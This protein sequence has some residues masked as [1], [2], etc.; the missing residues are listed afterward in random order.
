M[1]S[2]LVSKIRPG[3][4]YSYESSETSNRIVIML[5]ECEVIIFCF[6]HFEVGYKTI[7]KDR[8]RSSEHGQ[9]RIS[10]HCDRVSGIYP[11]VITKTM[12]VPLRSPLVTQRL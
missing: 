1:I 11:I 6:N 10:R 3:A 8:L 5:E 7:S 9:V 4:V 12:L 2:V